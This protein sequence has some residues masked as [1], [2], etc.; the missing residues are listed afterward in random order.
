M[1]VESE[2][3]SDAEGLIADAAYSVHYASLYT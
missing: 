1:S 2:K 3:E